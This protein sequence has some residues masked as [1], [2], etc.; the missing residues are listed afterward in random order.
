MSQRK[1]VE[2]DS[3]E[4]LSWDEHFEILKW[5]GERNDGLPEPDGDG[6]TYDV[7]H[8]KYGW[9]Q[10]GHFWHWTLR[11]IRDDKL[12]LGVYSEGQKKY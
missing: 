11:A 5:W 9:I 10:L 7:D 12:G 1:D 8:K 3:S 4:A 2:L 6:I